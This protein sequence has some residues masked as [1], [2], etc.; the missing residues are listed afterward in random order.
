MK[1][2]AKSPIFVRDGIGQKQAKDNYQDDVQQNAHTFSQYKGRYFIPGT[3]IKGM[4]RNVLEILSF[5]AMED[6]VNDHKYALRDLSGAMQ[7]QYLK[8]FKPDKIYCGWLKR[9]EDN[10]YAISDCGI[11]GRIGHDEIDRAYHTNFVSYF[12]VGGSFA[13][14]NDKEKSAQK[15]YQ[16]FGTTNNRQNK[17]TETS[18]P[19]GVKDGGRKLFRIDGSGKKEGTIVFTGQPGQRKRSFRK[20]EGA[21]L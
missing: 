13:A 16:L 21:L 17:F 14:Q 12:G 4:I 9:N 15:K 20:M 10:S 8:D 6:K 1:L 2:K 18:F 3:S 5:G 19:I 7:E 11:P